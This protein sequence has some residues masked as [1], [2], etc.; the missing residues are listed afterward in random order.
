[1]TARVEVP[2]RLSKEEKDLLRQLQEAQ[3]E[4]PRRKLGVES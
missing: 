4:S 3:G 1:V 2:S